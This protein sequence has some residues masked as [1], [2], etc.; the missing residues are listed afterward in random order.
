MATGLM[1][2]CASAPPTPEP[3]VVPAAPEPEAPIPKQQYLQG[4]ITLQ[5]EAV[6]SG[7]AALQ[8][9]LQWLVSGTIHNRGNR[10]I[11]WLEA[12]FHIMPRGAA[13]KHIVIDPLAGQD[14]IDAHGSRGFTLP[15]CPLEQGIAGQYDPEQSQ[16]PE[17][18][19]TIR[20]VDVKFADEGT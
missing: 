19:V 10:D 14:G 18:Q 6:F 1:W 2:G 16:W 15:V 12:E 11:S 8:A 9:G 13:Y 5:L 20:V 17:P 3:K 7:T 4:F